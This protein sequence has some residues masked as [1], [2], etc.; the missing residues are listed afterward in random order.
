[1]DVGEPE[2]A[3]LEAERQLGVIEAEQVQDGRLQIM[4]VNAILDSGKAQLVGFA[5]V[6]AGLDAVRGTRIL[7]KEPAASAPL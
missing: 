1:M 6:Q 4:D 7:V 2:I 3:A 5:E